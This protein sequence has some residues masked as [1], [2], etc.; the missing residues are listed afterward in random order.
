MSHVHEFD[1]EEVRAELG[2]LSNA[3]GELHDKVTEDH[4]DKIICSGYS[5]YASL[6][7]TAFMERAS[8][9]LSKKS[10]KIGFAGGFSGGKSTLINS[11]LSEPGLLAAEAGE[12]TMS[13]T[14]VTSPVEGGNDHVEIYYYTKENACKNLAGNNRYAQLFQPHAAAIVGEFDEEKFMAVVKEICSELEK[15]SDPDNRKKKPELEEFLHYL[16]NIE[17]RLGTV[18][19][20]SINNVDS[21]L[22]TDKNNK[23]LGHLLLIEQ[24]H[25]FRKNPLFVEK[26][27]EIVDLP[28]TD[29]T[30]VRQKE[31]THN[32][33]QMA[34][35]VILVIE[36]KGFKMA[37]VDISSEL[38]KHN[39][40]IRN[41]M[42]VVMNKFDTLD[43]TD[44]ARDSIKKLWGQVNE[45]FR[46]LQLSPDRIYLSSAK[47][48]ELTSRKDL[49]IITDNEKNDLEGLVQSSRNKLQA[50]D[51]GIEDDNPRLYNLM[52]RVY[53]DGGIENL[54]NNLVHYLENDIQRERMKEIFLDLDR[55]YQAAKRLI[56]SE[57]PTIERLKANQRGY[58]RQMV[59]FVEKTQDHFMEQ[60]RMI[61][62]GLN[63][64]AVNF[65]GKA[66][67]QVKEEIEG[68]RKF[69]F[70]KIKS[71]LSVPTPLNIK[72]EA[73]NMCKVR[74]SD[75]FASRVQEAMVKPV[76]DRLNSQIHES[77]IT[78]ILKHFSDQLGR[79]FSDELDRILAIFNQSIHEITLLRAR[80]ETWKL[81]ETDMRPAGFETAWSNQIEKTFK[82][83]IVK[84]F[85]DALLTRADALGHVIPRYYKNLMEDLIAQFEKLL[86]DLSENIKSV[87][88]VTIPVGLLTGEE[89]TEE[90]HKEMKLLEYFHLLESAEEIDDKLQGILIHEE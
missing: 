77:K 87:E 41:K 59:D 71:R 15:D 76:V 27:I 35:V 16:K 7:V 62:Q 47:R 12:C 89:E 80:E 48:V 88:K 60:V 2:S 9:K 68:F 45:E 6:P 36:P 78:P 49:G 3:L 28:G 42:F 11:L 82:D 44:I 57:K 72:M 61:E 23:G 1:I 14:M 51:K 75:M 69:P 39:N 67:K 54:R 65:I 4:Q 30:N 85:S 8:Q 79:D 83:D 29:S 84:T 10:Y 70:D 17:D 37:D 64:A 73:I 56:D 13:I 46:R 18:H 81:Q 40:E 66:K 32:Y 5:D 20:D 74:F 53:T 90:K 22:T 38:G 31:L 52:E 58:H 33:L 21:Y 24:V 55:V 86:D 34:D 63:K 25:I 19:I 50:L 43:A 26:G